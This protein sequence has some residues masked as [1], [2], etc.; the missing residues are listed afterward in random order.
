MALLLRIFQPS[1]RVVLQHPMLAAEMTLA[2]GAV[3]DYGLRKRL[4][5]RVSTPRLPGARSL[6]GRERDVDGGFWCDV[7]VLQSD[8]LIG[9]GGQV[10]AGVNQADLLGCGVSTQGNEMSQ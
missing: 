3:A 7:E 2:E 9:G 5:L 4:T 6:C 1:A 8:V 10:L